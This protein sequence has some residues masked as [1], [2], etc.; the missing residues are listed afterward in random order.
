MTEKCD[1]I[2][3]IRYKSLTK[4]Q[5]RPQ[6]TWCVSE[7]DTDSTEIQRHFYTGSHKSSHP[8]ILSLNAEV[9]HFKPNQ[10][11]GGV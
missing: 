4:Y 3:H 1:T 5:R 11:P 8:R 10:K 7:L 9:K 6:G 2:P